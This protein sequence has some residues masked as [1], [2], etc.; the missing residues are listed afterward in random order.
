MA[1]SSSG[2]FLSSAAIVTDHKLFHLFNGVR[3]SSSAYLREAVTG[4]RKKALCLLASLFVRAVCLLH[5]LKHALAKSC[6]VEYPNNVDARDC[7]HLR[8]K[9]ATSDSRERNI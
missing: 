5:C 8:L 2:N 9:G 6:I 1:C 3:F 4:R 7:W